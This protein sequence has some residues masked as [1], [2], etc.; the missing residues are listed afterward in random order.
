V[1]VVSCGIKFLA[2]AHKVVKKSCSQKEKRI[3]G[4]SA[5]SSRIL[6]QSHPWIFF[7]KTL[8]QRIQTMK[9]Q[10]FFFS[11]FD[12][13][14]CRCYSEEVSRIV[15]QE[16]ME[17]ENKIQKNAITDAVEMTVNDFNDLVMMEETI[18]KFSL[19]SWNHDK[20]SSVLSSKANT[21]RRFFQEESK[22]NELNRRVEVN[23]VPMQY[24]EQAA[25]KP[26]HLFQ[27]T[28]VSSDVFDQISLVGSDGLS[29]IGSFTYDSREEAQLDKAYAL[30]AYFRTEH[31][32]QLLFEDTIMQEESKMKDDTSIPL[33]INI[34]HN[35]VYDDFCQHFPDASSSNEESKENWFDPNDDDDYM[36]TNDWREFYEWRNQLANDLD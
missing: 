30:D 22:E 12:S 3:E 4:L 25:T 27:S 18:V 9:S 31:D 35:S 21:R 32:Q 5:A 8:S 17:D 1:V 13:S 7:L 34:T 33:T 24:I 29:S 16:Q 36:F 15:K 26:L 28:Q 19:K 20:K 23:E 2:T 11:I 10:Q 6:K 14:Q